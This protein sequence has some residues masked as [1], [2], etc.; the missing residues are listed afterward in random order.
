M[1]APWEQYG[2]SPA[3]DAGPWAAYTSS[4]P[5]AAR[6][7]ATVEDVAKSAGVGVGKGALALAG[8]AGDLGSLASSATD[9][10]GQKLG[11][12]PANIDRVKSMARQA[13]MATPLA[14]LSGPTTQDLTRTVQSVTG[15]FYKPKSVAGEYAQ[16]AGEF[17][18]GM[19]GGPAG[20]VRRAVTQVALPAAASETAGQVTKGTDAEPYARVAAAVLGGMVPSAIGRM[21]TPLPTSPERMAMVNTLRNEGVTDLTAGQITGRKGLQYFEAERGAPGIVERQGEQFTAAALR[22]AGETAKRASPEVIDNAF[23]RI[24]QNFDDLAAR[25]WAEFDGPFVQDLQRTHANYQSLVPASQRAPIVDDLISDIYQQHQS[26]GGVLT[27]EAYQAMRSRI[28]RLARGAKAD[29]QLADALSGIRSALDDV[30]ERTISVRN[31]A[32]LG[33]WREA[34][35]EYRNLL[36]LEKVAGGAGEAAAEG[37]LSPR[38]M[39]GAVVNQNKRAY[40]RG[41]GDFADLTRAGNAIMTPLPNSGTPGRML[42]QNMGTGVSSVVGAMLG[43]SVGGPA[44]GAAG[45]AAGAA[46][47]Y[48]LGRAAT[49]APGRAYLS[50]Q[51]ATN[52]LNGMTPRQSAVVNALLASRQLPQLEPAK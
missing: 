1:A 40:A 41:E 14:P 16:T 29:T 48:A 39:R 21:V 5:V 24:G 38:L 10:V 3:S 15:D 47:P 9:Y 43:G 31:P 2:T 13:T 7:S 28:D 20:L 17:A 49:S 36:V 27:G 52:M 6:E 19:L 35:N 26:S 33:S 42:A 8:L 32:D 37:L 18:P 46:L 11:A 30:T 44:G 45:A 50:N 23:T 22:R 34:R 25:N 51:V 12:D 4:P